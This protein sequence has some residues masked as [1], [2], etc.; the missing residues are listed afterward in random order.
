MVD[1]TEQRAQAKLMDDIACAS[2]MAD[3]KIKD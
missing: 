3:V 1:T 2:F